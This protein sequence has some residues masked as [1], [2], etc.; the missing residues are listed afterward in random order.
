MVIDSSAV[1]AILTG[2]AESTIF[3]EAISID[4]NCMMSPLTALESSIIWATVAHM[5]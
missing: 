3:A 2:E 5:L 1:I 4:N